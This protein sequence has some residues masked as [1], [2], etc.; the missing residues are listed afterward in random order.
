MNK[1]KKL[2][3]E[4]PQIFNKVIFSEKPRFMFAVISNYKMGQT[5]HLF[6][7]KIEAE[8]FYNQII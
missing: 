6:K 5:I 1:A 2:T 7:R 4:K 3:E 8:E